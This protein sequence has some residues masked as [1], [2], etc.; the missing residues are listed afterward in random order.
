MSLPGA[1][2]A[3]KKYKFDIQV[4]NVSRLCHA[5]PIVT[6]NGRF[7]GPTVYV[8]E[9]DRVLVNVTNH[10]EY[11]VSIH[12]HG[13]KQF[14][15][16]WADGPAYITQCPIQ[17]GNSYTYDFNV[18]G[19]RGTLWWHAHIL[20]LRATVHGAIVIMP[21]LGSQHPFPHPHREFN[22]LFGEWWHKDVEKVVKEGNHLGLPPNMSDAHTINGKPGPLFPCSE[23]HTFAMEVEAGKT[24]LLRIINAAL[25]DEL[26]F[27][28]AGHNMTV[29]EVDAVYTKPFTTHALLIAPGQTTNVLL[30]TNQPP[31]RYFMATRP[32]IDVPLAIDNKTA[33]AI[34]QYAGVPST[35]LPALP[36][37]PLSNDTAFA[38]SY[39]KMLRSLNSPQFPAVV[40]QAVDRKLFYTIGL[41]ENPCPTCTNGTRIAA[42]LNNISFVMPRVG[43]LQAH[44]FNMSGVFSTDFPD[45][46]PKA[47]NYTGAPLT[48]NLKTSQGTRLSRLAFNS[49][50]ELVLQ[51]T[52]LLTV[53]SHP[54]HLHGYNFFVVGT[55]IGNFDPRKDPSKFNLVDPPERNTVGVPTGGWTAIRFRADNPGVWFM[56]C[57]LELHTSWGLKMAFVVEDGKGAGQSILPPPKDLPPC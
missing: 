54:F 21:P 52:N 6:V 43:L 35:L 42:S 19:Q 49:T 4:K 12:W 34:L 18:T 28:V 33:T 39:N 56:H 11:N 16:G 36:L 5:K 10:A 38:L 47:F 17:T 29:V 53:E 45:R 27:A 15:N 25:N 40:P 24:Y 7:P 26:F 14:R 30:H 55:G 44:Y 3:T 31:A 46:P 23:K 51:D 37:L 2:A 41:G 1:E 20:W 57:H 22:L 48:A 9:G 32:F 8:R 50:V 13:L